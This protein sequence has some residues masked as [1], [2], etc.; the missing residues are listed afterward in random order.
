M[1]GKR[2]RLFSNDY[3]KND[4]SYGRGEPETSAFYYW[5]LFMARAQREYHHLVDDQVKEDFGDVTQPFEQWWHEK[6]DY[7]FKPP[8]LWRVRHLRNV[9]M[10]HD[11]KEN[12]YL[13]AVN[14]NYTKGELIRGMKQAIN[15]AISQDNYTPQKPKYFF[16]QQPVIQGLR[17]AHMC[18]VAQD[19]LRA[20]GADVS[21]YSIAAK[22]DEHFQLTGAHRWLPFPIV[23]GVTLPQ[24]KIAIKNRVGAKVSRHL[25][26][27]NS[28]IVNVGKGKFPCYD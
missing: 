13:F 6:G 4:R 10:Y 5:Y 9:G 19:L 11:L 22:V 1:A 8:S 24:D 2:K 26:K 16:H 18:K 12:S 3:L 28:L 17:S 23:D 20:E 14:K 27:A 15:V 21:N 25:R 7:L